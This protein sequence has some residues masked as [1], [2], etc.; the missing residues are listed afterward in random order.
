M[1]RTAG[2]AG[3]LSYRTSLEEVTDE[4]PDISE[5]LESAFYNWC[6]YNDNA[7]IAVT[8][9][10]KWLGKSN[11]VGSI[12]S[13]WL[14]IFNGTVVLRTTLSWITSIEE[15]TDENKA[16]ITKLDKAIQECPNNE[17]HVIVEGGKGE[18]K[19][20]SEHPFDRYPDF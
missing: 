19:Y 8:K 7:G 11:C 12:M 20:W 16:S 5:Y 6:W 17:T 18:P 13:Y 4:N 10:E 2:S 3:S 9:L 1:Q 14:L 15:Q